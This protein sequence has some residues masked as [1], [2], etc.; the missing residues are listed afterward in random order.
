MLVLPKRKTTLQW[1]HAIGPCDVMQLIDAVFSNLGYNTL[2]LSWPQRKP[3]PVDLKLP[4]IRWS[5][6]CDVLRALSC[7]TEDL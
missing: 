3:E 5:N 6:V 1:Q 2:Q 7:S 4:N